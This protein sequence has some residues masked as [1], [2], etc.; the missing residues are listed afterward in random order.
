MHNNTTDE[1]I[2]QPRRGKN[3]PALPTDVIITMIPSDLAYLTGKIGAKIVTFS[4]FSLCPV[5]M[6]EE[7][8]EA[9]PAIAGPFT[10]AP[11]AVIGLEKLI[12]L[13]AKRIWVLGWCGSLQ[14]NVR[15]GDIILP[16][17]AI[18]EEGTSQHYPVGKKPVAPNENLLQILRNQMAQENVPFAP[19]S[20]WTTDAIY[21][22]TPEKVRKF[23]G[24]GVLGVEMELSAL[25]TVALY[26][27]VGL[28]G[29]LVVSDE[30]F[31]LQWKPGFA[32]PALKN[33]SRRAAGILLSATGRQADQGFL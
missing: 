11:Q 31:D 20:V 4:G 30:L 33:G 10:G 2:I 9:F 6:K 19:G 14:P 21:R 12:A 18:S 16:T 15:I 28:A 1:G 25:F 23:Q 27:S 29:L 13:G 32:S 24:L 17:L 22:E 7:R 3:D 26:R 8:K 5:Y